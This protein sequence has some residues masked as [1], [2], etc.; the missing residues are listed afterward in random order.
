MTSSTQKVWR[1]SV[2]L[3]NSSG[4]FLH[5]LPLKFLLSPATF[6]LDTKYKLCCWWKAIEL[7]FVSGY[8][9][10]IEPDLRLALVY[11]R[12]QGSYIDI[13]I[14][15]NSLGLYTGPQWID[16]CYF[17]Q[18]VRSVILFASTG[19]TTMGSTIK[20]VDCYYFFSITMGTLL[21]FCHTTM[22]SSIM[23]F[24]ASKD[25]Q[26]VSWHVWRSQNLVYKKTC[27]YI[28]LKHWQLYSLGKVTYR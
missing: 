19:S 4:R 3:R 18:V 16:Q 11:H 23:L 1:I 28:N 8:I 10:K 9:C 21:L 27:S 5:G 26:F 15:S 25:P 22:G 12:A 14:Y 7:K 13:S 20:W 24:C 6:W 17:L 2:I